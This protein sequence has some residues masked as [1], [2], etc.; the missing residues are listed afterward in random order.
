MATADSTHYGIIYRIRHE[1]SGKV[2]IGQTVGRLNDRWRSHNKQSYCALLSRAL[3]KY[4]PEAFSVT[5]LSKAHSKDELNQLEIKHIKAYDSLNRDKGYNLREGGSFGKH[6][7]ESKAKMSIASR[8]AH[9]NPEYVEKLRIART[10]KK[11]SDEFRAAASKR[12]TGTKQSKETKAKLAKIVQTTWQSCEYKIKV[13][14]GQA[15]ARADA[16]YIDRVAKKSVAQWQ[17]PEA[18]RLLLEA[19]AAGKRAMWADPVRKAAF[20]EKRRATNA[21]K[22]AAQ[23]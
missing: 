16:D 23:I 13:S 5:E 11:R 9:A 19:Q 22:K 17:D 8:R 15:K 4:G 12:M 6:S 21:A 3:K 20:L 10:G 2:Y 1:A 14:E 18:R 7:A